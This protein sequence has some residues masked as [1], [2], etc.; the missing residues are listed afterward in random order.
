MISMHVGVLRCALGARLAAG[1]EQAQVGQR[2]CQVV[3]LRQLRQLRLRH[4][5]RGGHLPINLLFI[6]G[7]YLGIS[8]TMHEH[9]ISLRT[10]RAPSF[11]TATNLDAKNAAR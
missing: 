5:Q 1:V 8:N 4:A 3:L 6:S 2:G 10:V 11:G 9:D 7:A